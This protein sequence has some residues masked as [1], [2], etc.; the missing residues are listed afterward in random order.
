MVDEMWICSATDILSDILIHSRLHK[1]DVEAERAVILREAE[2]VA[3]NLQVIC[4]FI[5]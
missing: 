3:Q 2:E 1:T 5:I 4:C